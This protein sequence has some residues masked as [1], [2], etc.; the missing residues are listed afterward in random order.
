M[1]EMSHDSPVA[2]VAFTNAARRLAAKSWAGAAGAVGV[3]VLVVGFLSWP[4]VFTRSG[5]EGDWDVHLWYVWRQ[6][7]AIASNHAPT[8]F[9]NDDASVFYPVYA[10]YNS[11]I[12]ALTGGLGVILGSTVT[13]YVISYVAGF[14]A[15]Y[16]GWYWLAHMAGLRRWAAH[17]PGLVFVTSAYYLTNVYSR[18]DWAEFI[19]VS[20]IPLLAASVLH[21]LFAERLAVLPAIALAGSTLVFFG[22]HN[23]TILW[24]ASTLGAVGLALLA[25]V[26]QLRRRITRRGVIRVARLLIPAA[27]IN[28]WYL[29]STA[30]FGPRVWLVHEFGYAHSLRATSNLVAAHHLFTFSRA[31]VSPLLRNFTLALPVLALVWVIIGVAVSLGRPEGGP[32]RRA[33]WI[34]AAAGLVV[35]ILMTHPNLE[36]DLPAPYAIIQYEY[37][38]ESYVLLTLCA[39]ILALLVI[40]RS[41]PRRWRIWSWSVGIVVAVSVIG[42]V[43]QVDSYSHT[44][45]RH[46]T[47]AS[48]DPPL[49][50]RLEGKLSDFKDTTEPTV[51]PAGLPEIRFPPTA[52]R[53]ER[54]AISVN[55]PSGQLAS[56]NLAAAPYFAKVTGA[57]VVGRTQDGLMVLRV[58]AHASGSSQRI[59]VARADSAPIVLGRV[60]ALLSLAFLAISLALAAFG[61]LRG[62]DEARWRRSHC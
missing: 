48:S 5:M 38:L 50:A 58:G 41:W 14:A 43:Q 7:L 20:T 61:R 53:H 16:G 62:G 34:F 6:G 32:W 11:T 23:I 24:G 13:G 30:A 49:P 25:V 1:S 22:S 46:Q 4:I 42:A 29:L 17:A 47:F 37:R 2:T 3:G 9:T 19:A 39:A 28:S 56:S 55:L 51:N 54:V 35:G 27:L 8:L 18:G 60:I 10:F 59:T 31:T 57:D 45:D 26:P 44:H 21:V 40:A 33:L 36:L 52:V 12:D 15:A